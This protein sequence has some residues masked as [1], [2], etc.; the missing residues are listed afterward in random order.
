MQDEEFLQWSETWEPLRGACLN[1]IPKH[2]HTHTPGPEADSDISVFIHHPS[3]SPFLVLL[4]QVL[5]LNQKLIN[6]ARLTL[7]GQ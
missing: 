4:R 7:T 3:L 1:L 6:A 2:T 5:P